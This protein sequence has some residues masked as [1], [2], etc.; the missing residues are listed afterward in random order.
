MRF[1]LRPGVRRLF[2]LP[3]RGAPSIHADIDDELESLLA[4]RVEDF[5]ARGMSPDDARAEAVR[6]LGVNLDIARH[7]LHTSAEQRERHMRLSEYIE[8]VMQD[9]R[10]AGRGLARRPAFTIVAVLTL[11]IGIG[12]TTAIFSAVNTLLLRPLPYASPEQL[13]AVSLTT[14]DNGARKG[15][16]DMVWSYPKFLVFRDGQTSFSS[17]ALYTQQQLTATSGDVEQ[18][19]M[20][21]VGATYLRTLGL[22]PVRGRDFDPALDAHPDAEKQVVL[23][24]SLWQRR[25]NADPNVIGKT[26]ELNGEPYVIIGIGPENFRGL[27]GQAELFVPVTTRH[28]KD[29]LDQ[30]FSHEFFLVAR[31]KPGV[32]ASAATNAVV[33][34][35]RR[36]RETIVDSRMG[37]GQWGATARPLNDVR[38][39]PLIRRSL[40]ILFGAVGFVLLIACVNVA[41]LLLGRAAARRR[42]IAVRLAIGAG[43]AR[44]VRLLLTE[45]LLLAGAG[46]AAGLLVALAGVRA[47]SA[48]NPAT[49]LRVAR[50]GGVGSVT[51]SLIRLDWMALAFALGMTAIVGL[52]FGLV[53]AL[54]ATRVSFASAMKD[55]PNESRGRASASRRMLVIAE[56]SLAMVLLAGSGLMIRSLGKLLAIDMGF[57]AHNVLT[58]RM[59][60]PPG[61]MA[62]DSM[63]AFFMAVVER[64]R[65]LPGVVDVAL[66]SCAP[67]GG[68]CNAT[69]AELMDRPKVDFSLMPNIGVAWASPTW[70]ATMGIPKK[71][72]RMFTQADRVGAAKVIVINETAARAFW[73]GGDALG[74]RIGIGQGGFSDGAEVVGVVGDT[75]QHADSLPRADSYLPYLQSPIGRMIIFVRTASD[76]SLIGPDVRRV[77]H[78]IAPRYA[79]YDMQPMSTRTTAATAQAR[80]SATLLGLFA[81]TALSLAVIGIY[82]VMSLAVSTRTREIGIRIALGADQRRVR[83]LVV[84]EGLGLVAAGAA[85]GIG[86]ALL[87]TRVLQTM[88]FNLSA[89]DPGTYVGIVALLGVA[90]TAASWIPARRAARVDPVV[91]LRAD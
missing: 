74:K 73:P 49:T 11:A 68:G 78:E 87:C 42:E 20:E 18:L 21:F 30:M 66:G 47:L 53:P 67:L 16:N 79:I 10:Y 81:A 29:D 40:F 31:R 60:I 62:R 50:F 37:D 5:M 57:D 34:M 7:Q 84:W 1:N 4:A 80:F 64:L 89:S 15:R 25:Y 41:N 3:L 17:L 23:T 71:R 6:R 63:P 32:S 46:G 24:N 56:V 51:F 39:A 2:R 45:S 82:G 38:V 88:L 48:I 58:A 86:G 77:M 54:D 72:G 55:A 13:M 75:R 33:V 12:A 35:G 69:K 76:P 27:T 65:A 83:R 36:V 70:F 43:R 85:I 44:L 52:V 8:D 61:G 26:I 22:A 9:L 91:A 90:A 19:P 59:S 14:P 28:A